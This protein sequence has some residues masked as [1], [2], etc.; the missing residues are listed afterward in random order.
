[1]MALKGLAR[2]AKEAQVSKD[3]EE[4]RSAE[5]DSPVFQLLEQAEAGKGAGDGPEYPLSDV[6][7]KNKGTLS[8]VAEYRKIL[9]SGFI[10]GI[11]APELLCPLLRNGGAACIAVATEPLTGGCSDA[12]LKTVVEEQENSRGDFPGPMPVIIR[13]LVISE[14][15]IARAKA[16]GAAGVTVVLA[17]VGPERAAELAA[18]SKKLGMEAVIQATSQEEIEQAVTSEDISIISIVGK[19]VDEAVELRQ[20]IPD[21]VVSVVHVDRRS[22]EGMD[23]IEDCWQLRDAGYHTIWASEVLYKGGMMQAESAEAILKAIRAKASVK[24]GRARGMSGKGEGAK[25][26]LGYLAQ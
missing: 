25:E 12:D 14:F 23:E 22:D 11:L 21:R 3:M 8:V 15:E 26:Y 5:P 19:M 1:M 18:F 4:L 9:K 13:D 10:D 7:R 2:K 16:A 6:L 24:Y 17:L 20:Y